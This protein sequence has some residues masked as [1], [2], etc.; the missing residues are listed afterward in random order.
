MN[1]TNMFQYVVLY[2]KKITYNIKYP[3]L[4]V[5]DRALLVLSHL[6]SPDCSLVY[7]STSW[8]LSETPGIPELA[9]VI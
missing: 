2:Y 9:V 8:S 7:L 1:V 5:A 4:G 3:L 6:W